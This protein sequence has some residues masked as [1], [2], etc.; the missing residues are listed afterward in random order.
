MNVLERFSIKVA[1]SDLQD[2][3]GQPS[4]LWKICMFIMLTFIKSFDYE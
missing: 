4:T 3:I 1:L 2:P